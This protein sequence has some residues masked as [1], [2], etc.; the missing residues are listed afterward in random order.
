MQDISKVNLVSEVF[1]YRFFISSLIIFHLLYLLCFLNLSI[2]NEKFVLFLNS[3][4]Q[5]FVC[6]F[7]MIKYNPLRKPEFNKNDS[8][9][10]FTSASFI[11]FNLA[12]N[13]GLQEIFDKYKNYFQKNKKEPVIM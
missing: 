7:L 4:I 3:F 9:L 13:L 12:L 11:L 1:L 8:F 5:F 2:F 10:I 6:V